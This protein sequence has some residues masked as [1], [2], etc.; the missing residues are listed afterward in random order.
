MPIPRQ[1][2]CS[3]AG[4]GGGSAAWWHC[5]AGE[6]DEARPFLEWGW[7]LSFSGILTYTKAGNVREAAE[8]APLDSCLLETDAPWLTPRQEGRS[9]NEPAFVVHT[10]HELARVKG[11][12]RS[13]VAAATTANACRVFG[14]PDS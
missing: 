4:P 6:A 12:S 8:L 7:P 14:L 13:A 5:F 9:M 2:G 11:L 3:R 10:A 1:R